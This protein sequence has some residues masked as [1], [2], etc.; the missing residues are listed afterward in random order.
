LCH[1]D[2]QPC[3]ASDYRFI[4]VIAVVHQTRAVIISKM[5]PM[6]EHTGPIRRA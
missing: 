1:L 2:V 3:P 6:F 4:L 5:G